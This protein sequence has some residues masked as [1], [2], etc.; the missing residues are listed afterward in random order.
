MV[1]HP[2][3]QPAHTGASMP[4]VGPPLQN[5][6]R[7]PGQVAPWR[8]ID[9]LAGSGVHPPA[10][11]RAAQACAAAARSPFH[12]QVRNGHRRRGPRP[13]QNQKQNLLL[14]FHPLWRRSQRKRL[15]GLLGHARR[16]AGLKRH[17]RRVRRQDGPGHG[18]RRQSSL[19]LCPQ[20]LLL[21]R[22]AQGLPD[23]PV[24]AA[25]LRARPRGHYR[26]RRGQTHRHHPHP[27]GRGRRQEHPL[28]RRQLE[29]RGPQP[30]LRA[31]YRDRVRAGHA[32]PRGSRGLLK[33]PARH[34][35]LPRRV[36]R[37]HGGGL[38]SLRRQREPA[39]CRPSRVRHPGGTE[40]L[41]QLPPRPESH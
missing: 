2:R 24:R 20:E 6:N 8:A 23:L 1:G 33:G 4:V 15:P 41:K 37:Q 26:G 30:G 16:V 28:R 38:L 29:L 27:H 31:A 21:S 22:S 9:R 3:R 7:L 11:F 25:H 19:G 12:G 10:K 5:Y 36:R 18:L 32:R 35:R 14:L 39:P 17:G 34:P 13:A 40:K